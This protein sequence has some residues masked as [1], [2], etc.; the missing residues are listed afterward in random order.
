MHGISNLTLL[1]GC[2]VDRVRQMNYKFL[3][4]CSGPQLPRHL[5]LEDVNFRIRRYILQ[6][7]SLSHPAAMHVGRSVGW[8][9]G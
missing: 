7:L 9:G 2:G 4:P 6:L 5:M 1:A 8:L 3:G